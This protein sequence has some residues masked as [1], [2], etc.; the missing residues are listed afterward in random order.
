MAIKLKGG[1][2]GLNSLAISEGTFY[3]ASL[4]LVGIIQICGCRTF[5]LQQLRFPLSDQSIVLGVLYIMPDFCMVGI[6][7]EIWDQY[8]EHHVGRRIWIHCCGS[9]SDQYVKLRKNALT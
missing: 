6:Q 9:G 8:I 4:S 7:D 5:H 1:G 3:A 2:V